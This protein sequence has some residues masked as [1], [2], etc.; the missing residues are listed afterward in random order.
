MTAKPDFF[1]KVERGG[2]GGAVPLLRW[3][4]TDFGA[5]VRAAH[6]VGRYACFRV[7]PFA[8]PS[9]PTI[10]L[11]LRLAQEL[12][13]AIDFGVIDPATLTEFGRCIAEAECA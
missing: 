10:T 6:A 3:A 9:E 8:P 2:R 7:D 11:P 13:R 5:R 12:R 4:P 1:V